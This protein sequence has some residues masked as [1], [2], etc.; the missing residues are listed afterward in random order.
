MVA[1]ESA[2]MHSLVTGA[3]AVLVDDVVTTGASLAAASAALER[4][5]VAVVAGLT[6]ASAPGGGAHVTKAL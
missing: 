2:A 6:L 5:G 1:R 3:A 4:A